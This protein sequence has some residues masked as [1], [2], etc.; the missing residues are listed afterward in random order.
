VVGDDDGVS[1]AGSALSGTQTSAKKVII[2]EGTFSLFRRPV[3]YFLYR[4]SD[5]ESNSRRADQRL[6][7]KW[8]VIGLRSCIA[9]TTSYGI[10]FANVETN[11]IGSVYCSWSRKDWGY[12]I[13]QVMLLNG[14]RSP[15]R[16]IQ[17]TSRCGVQSYSTRRNA[18]FPICTFL[19]YRI[20]CY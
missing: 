8:P 7:G 14:R 4:P 16:A 3:D 18:H 10:P 19:S 1:E 12:S 6:S 20:C 15:N 11:E 2:T 5:A 9:H 17:M 13:I